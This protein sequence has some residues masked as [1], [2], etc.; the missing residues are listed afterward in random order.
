MTGTPKPT[1][2][3]ATLERLKHSG[4]LDALTRRKPAPP[5]LGAQE[6]PIDRILPDPDQPRRS[7]D[8]ERLAS[9]SESIKAQGVLQPITVQ[10]ADDQGHHVII[11]G[12]R[13]YQ[14]SKL[15]GLSSIPVLIKGVTPEL[16]MAQLTENVQR[17][18]L[19]TLEIA[20]AVTAM[21]AAGQGR[22]EIAKALGWSE[23]EVSRF[24]SVANMPED[25]QQ[26]AEADVPIRA[27]AD[28]N[29]LWKR[30]PDSVS[31]FLRVTAAQEITRIRVEALRK[32]IE[33]SERDAAQRS[34]T[35]PGPHGE[36]E[37]DTDTASMARADR[38]E[39]SN[40]PQPVEAPQHT[41]PDANNKS[42]A[43]T[44]I[45]LICRVGE[46]IGHIDTWSMPSI[47]RHVIVQF[48]KDAR[49]AETPLDQ[50]Q[51]VDVEPLA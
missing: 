13:R 42:R 32:Q 50:V 27:L 4:Q 10:P 34:E 30:A 38:A 18:D 2:T 46:E 44:K 9:L 35:I 21:R 48:E 11:M 28:L 7:F 20:Q 8:R 6:I 29:A 49:I 15:A 22:A 26:L 47:P 16:R 39:P 51:I 25:L 3:T 43:E 19:N 36:E 23:G 1:S 37:G 31:E 17:E 14:A 24:G 41:V 12:E 45:A 5:V 33:Q 40:I